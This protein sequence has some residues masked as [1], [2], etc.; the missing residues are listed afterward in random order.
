[1][2]ENTDMEKSRAADLEETFTQILAINSLR[3][4]VVHNVDGSEQEFEDWDPS[5]RYVT[6]LSK[7]ELVRGAHAAAIGLR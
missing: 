3:D 2:S 4:F 6:D 7:L 5:K 1:M